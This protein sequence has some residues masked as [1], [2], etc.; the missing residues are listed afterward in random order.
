MVVSKHCLL[1]RSSSILPGD[2]NDSFSASGMM[3]LCLVQFVSCYASNLCD[4]CY[5]MQL[6]LPSS[7][8]EL[9]VVYCSGDSFVSENRLNSKT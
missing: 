4:A 3:M 9:L 1:F 7:P 6:S 2:F 8:V 5:S